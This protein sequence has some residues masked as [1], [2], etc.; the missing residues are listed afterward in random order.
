MHIKRSYSSLFGW[1]LLAAIFV[2]LLPATSSAQLSISVNFGPP[3]LPVY[4]QP[5]CPAEGYIWTPGYWA[6]NPDYGDYYW[7]PGTWVLA[8]QPGFLWTPAWWGW[9]GGVFLFHEGF[10]GPHVGFYGGIVYGF[11]Y[12]GEGYEGGR[13][14]HDRFY[15]NQT[16]NNV[17]VTNIHNTYNTTVIN[18]TTV[19]RVSYNGGEGGVTARPRPEDEV[20]ARER[21]LPPVPAQSEHIQAARSN[22]ELRASANQ[23]KPPVAATPKPGA[24]RDRAVVPAKAAGG[25]YTPPPNRGGGRPEG[26]SAVPRPGNNVPRPGNNASRPENNPAARPENNVPRP[27]DNAPRPENNNVPRPPV[28]GH[29]K[30]LQPHERP[31]PVNTGNAKQDQK[32]QQQQDKLYQRQEQEHQKLQQKQEQEHQRMQQRNADEARRQQMEQKHQQQ[33]QQMEQK[34]N[35]QEQKMQS[36]QQPR[37]SGHQ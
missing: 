15:Y 9:D 2:M 16:V 28:P 19:N 12:T 21:H 22:P 14:D 37:P 30:D 34:H 1:L 4:E 33:T 23:G 35:Q 27:G 29:A 11:G 8:P 7:V 6:Y 36:K 5:P 24:F 25:T 26:N 32:Y 31:A 17:N 13:W 18:N 20:A 10:W 3:P